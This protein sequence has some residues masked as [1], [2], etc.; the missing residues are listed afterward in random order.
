[1]KRKVQNLFLFASYFNNI[2]YKFIIKK[3]RIKQLN[4]HFNC[5]NEHIYPFTKDFFYKYN[6]KLINEN[7][8]YNGIMRFPTKK[9]W[10]DL[11]GVERKLYL[12]R[13]KKDIVENNKF[14]KNNN[15]FN[16]YYNKNNKQKTKEFTNFNYKNNKLN[17]IIEYS[18]NK[19]VNKSISTIDTSKFKNNTN[20]DLKKSN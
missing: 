10:Y 13:D 3:Y 9:N 12:F 4:I 8:H 6:G 19:K 2:F 15:K 5:I 20:S 17:N 1:M 18:N 14:K 7:Y 16:K 11:F